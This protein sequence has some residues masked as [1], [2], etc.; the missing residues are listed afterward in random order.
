[1]LSPRNG[2]YHNQKIPSYFDHLAYHLTPFPRVTSS[3]PE[4]EPEPNERE[5]VEG[6]GPPHMR[7]P[8]N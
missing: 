7:R 5:D 1:M 8:Y 4:Q 6:F 3:A 2:H